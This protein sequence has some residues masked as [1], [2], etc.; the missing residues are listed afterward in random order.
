MTHTALYLQHKELLG[1]AIEA[2]S[3]RQFFS[4]YPEHPKAYDSGLD[5]KGKEAFC[6]LLNESFMQR[7]QY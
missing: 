4:P 6:R 1:Q 5:S 2:L 3:T 7:N